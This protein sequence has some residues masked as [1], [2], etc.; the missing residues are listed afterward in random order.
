MVAKMKVWMVDF[1]QNHGFVGVI[2]MSAWPNAFFDLC[3]MCCGHFLMPF[4]QFLG[5]TLIGKALIKSNLQAA[6]FIMIFSEWHITKFLTFVASFTG[7][8]SLKSYIETYVKQLISKFQNEKKGSND[9]QGLSLGALWGYVV[10]TLIAYFVK[11]SIEQFAQSYQAEID[12]QYM[13][14]NLAEHS[15]ESVPADVGSLDNKVDTTVVR[16]RKNTSTASAA[17]SI[18]GTK[19]AAGKSSTKKNS[20]KSTAAKKS[21]TKSSNKS[22]SKTSVKDKAASPRPPK[23]ST[24]PSSKDKSKEKRM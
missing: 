22:S 1:L 12:V 11:S 24:K 6:F 14:D 19:K 9:E 13:L 4:W 3:G 10:M 15:V 16:N 2:L 8:E 20:A 7:S 17:S 5:A 21:S 23:S 18:E